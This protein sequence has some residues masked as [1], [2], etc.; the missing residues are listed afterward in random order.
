MAKRNFLL[1]KGER[2]VED[3]AGVRGGAPKSHPY[4]FAEA[5]DR[6][7][8]MLARVVR[9]IDHLP[10]EACPN[11]AAVAAV[12]LN[13]EYIAK[14]YFPEKLLEAVGL[15]PVGSRPRRIT[16]EKRSKGREPEEAITTE[17]FV[18][19][20]RSAFRA[21]RSQ[22][23][24][25]AEDAVGAKDLP[26]IEQISAPTARDKV[27]GRVPK[28]GKVV[29]EVVLHSSGGVKGVVTQFQE[30]LKKIGLEQPLGR[31]FDA[32]GLS[33]VELEAPVE[34][35]ERIATFTP[36]RAV[37]QMPMLRILRPSFR[38]SRV[39]MET[40]ELSTKGPVDPSIRV[41]IF[42]GGLPKGHPV[43]K[44]A[45]PIDPPGIGAAWDEFQKHGVGVTSAFLFGH[46][47]PS[48]PLGRPYA[49]VDH[50]RVLDTMP[51]QDPHE[52][53][54]VLGRIDSVLVNKKYDFI[55]LSIGPYPPVEDDDVHAWTAVL[56]DRLSH[57][58]TLATIAVGNNG[59][60]PAKDGLNRIQVPSDCVNALA[61]GAC[62]NYETPWQ[63][64]V[65][66]SVGP[67]R[68]PGVVKP[69]FVEFG[70]NLQRPFI[71]VHDGRELALEATEGTSFSAPS[72]MR[73][74]AGVR[75]HFGTNLGILAIRALLV[76]TTEPSDFPC[77]DVGRGRVAR[78]LDE[79]V[80]CDDDTVRVVYQGI[81]A[82]AR[83]IRAPI[84][85]P[86]GTIPGKVTITATLCYPT[87]VDPHHPGNYTRAGLEPTFRPHDQKRK[88][89]KQAHPD[90]KGFF[91]KTQSGL[92]EDELRRDAWKW[93]NC[94]HTSV[95]FMGK[96]LRNPV[97]DIHYNAR[98]AGRDFAPK[99]ALPYALVVSVHAK[100]L[101]DL[102][103]RVV[104][105]YAKQL[106]ALRPVVEIPVN[107]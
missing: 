32:G 90:S 66:S 56:D 39:P 93:E 19:G 67:G 38:S 102:Y 96:T 53:Y 9:G 21:W 97:L 27:K 79:I 68:S 106:E 69:D 46:I 22:L 40:I 78:S 11:D 7:V 83:Y 15:E 12:T 50:Y 95:T 3:V 103:D 8:P 76:H 64:C 87:G 14:S 37:R 20:P 92:M 33:F 47:D 4:T 25:F 10:P 57:G 51:G 49:P 58:D 82:P 31:R 89:P 1:G 59:S 104:R 18:M 42:D 77:E 98:Q 70:G 88:D 61:V 45:K 23:V 5:K 17:L 72:V 41:A 29:F 75:A 44:W 84:P 36:V 6:I 43:T 55:N 28:T 80:L 94:L 85:V 35:V 34:A 99:E 100:H 81:I 105:K 73:L 16:P 101:G 71:V 86:S 60:R 26:S 62:D 74:G 107:T 30:Y 24:N 2:L 13:P 91:G 54:E 63:R 52:L 65:Y 48:K